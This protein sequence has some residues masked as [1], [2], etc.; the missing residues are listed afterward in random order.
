MAIVT[1]PA[2]NIR[3]TEPA[4]IAAFLASCRGERAVAVSG[5]DGLRALRTAITITEKL[6]PAT[7]GFP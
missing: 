2:E 6:R 5:E 1:V 4:E 3:L 7:A